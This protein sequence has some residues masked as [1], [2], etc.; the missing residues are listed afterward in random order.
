MQESKLKEPIYEASGQ[1][2]GAIGPVIGL[3]VGVGIAVLVLIFVGT[4]GGQAYQ[5][6]EANIEAIGNHSASTVFTANNVTAQS[7]GHP[8]IHT[9]SLTI[10]NGTID[11]GL[12]N[13]T[14]NY[15]SGTALL[16]ASGF[17]WNGSSMTATYTWGNT[18]VKGYVKDSV[19]SGFSALKQTGDYLPIVV[20]AVI[21]SLVLML[22]MGFTAMGG[23]A[24][25]TSAL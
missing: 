4:L 11:V 13:W 18:S 8:E 23:G 21:I 19:V 6:S 24:G 20:L 2:F 7:L 9:G 10:N 5:L 1:S 12:G 22:V 14:I 3:I 15:G 25:R 16:K 17:E